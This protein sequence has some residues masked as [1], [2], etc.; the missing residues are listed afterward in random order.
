MQNII[1]MVI[2]LKRELYRFEKAQQEDDIILDLTIFENGVP[3]DIT[4]ATIELIYVNANNTVA[5]ITGDS[6]VIS[7]NNVKITC[8]RDCTRSAGVAKFQLKI[9]SLNKQVSTFPIGL[10][11][12]PG[13]NQG[14]AISQN[15]STI[16]EELTAMNVTANETIES[17]NAWVNTH[18]NIVNLD[19]RVTATESQLAE[20]QIKNLATDN[21]ISTLMDSVD[22]IMT[23]DS[24]KGRTLKNEVKNGVFS[25]ASPPWRYWSAA[26]GTVTV[27]NK[28][29]SLTSNGQARECFLQQD[30]IFNSTS[31]KYYI[32][33]EARVT[34]DVCD[35][36]AIGSFT[37]PGYARVTKPQNGVWYK[38]TGMKQGYTDKRF[39]IDH[40]YVDATT[41][42]GKVLEVTNV[43]CIN[44]TQMFGVN[45]EPTQEWCDQNIQWFN[46]IKS[47]GEQEGDKVLVS[48]VGKNLIDVSKD[49][50]RINNV[51]STKI[52][53][54]FILEA[55]QSQTSSYGRYLLRVKSNTKYTIQRDFRVLSGGVAS[56]G[57]TVI[58]D[59]DARNV[60][61]DASP[62]NKY[63]AFTSPS[64]GYICVLFY[65]KVVETTAGAKV[66]FYN[67][68][69]EEGEVAT[70]VEP[71]KSDN[72]EI[73]LK[74]PHMGLPT[75]QNEIANGKLIK[76]INKKVL[77]GNETWALSTQKVDTISFVLYDNDVL[78]RIEVNILSDKFISYD[79]NYLAAN[80]VEGISN[81]YNI[82]TL[83]GIYIRIAKTKLS[84]P[85]VAGFK[86][87]LQSNPTTIQYE[88]A[89]PTEEVI[90][91]P[92]LKSFKNGTLYLNNAIT[93]TVS[94]KYPSNINSRLQSVETE[95]DR[96]FDNIGGIWKSLL[97]LADRELRMKS[98]TLL[99][100]ETNAD[101]KNKINEILNV[102]R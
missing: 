86:A 73:Q 68:Q 37:G 61:I 56:T 71:Y 93:P 102:W 26:Y 100:T 2:D 77:N 29:L 34:N 31:D 98:I 33:T 23:V 18:G 9:I 83:R 6:V 99:T 65:A 30:G 20:N 43:M 19:N 13:V 101:L 69:L 38:I 80:D 41:A 63:V 90:S 72:L 45:K 15:I 46:G 51:T 94:L 60:I 1:T 47:V 8:P 42:N 36:I 16:L 67:I 58:T 96:A 57:R 91:L 28:V 70:Q 14:Q 12:T 78:K 88:L 49:F 59:K 39:I 3:K 44:L 89:T 62:S 81:L 50:Y 87:W 22:G 35:Y 95:L 82:S 21:S 7:A 17:L 10:V 40:I 92:S 84:T 48:S 66:E 79:A 85:D 11:I 5:N 25:E 64:D 4:G 52:E 76:R 54:G 32:S 53:N 27:N 75:V 24:I 55:T 74:E 97:S